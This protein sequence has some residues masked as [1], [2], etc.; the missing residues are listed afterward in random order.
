MLLRKGL[1]L[2]I[3]VRN[4]TGIVYLQLTFTKLFFF[5]FTGSLII[6]TSFS[7]ISNLLATISNT[8]TMKIEPSKL[9]FSLHT[10]LLEP[11]SHLHSLLDPPPVCV[12]LPPH[13][14]DFCQYT[15]RFHFI[16]QDSKICVLLSSLF[17]R[18]LNSA[19]PLHCIKTWWSYFHVTLH[20]PDLAAGL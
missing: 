15:H 18:V 20:I 7:K 14:H 1:I 13:S 4:H 2:I 17:T 19:V 8:C 9:C 12:W 3:L 11:A 16:Q 6:E 10:Y 5:S